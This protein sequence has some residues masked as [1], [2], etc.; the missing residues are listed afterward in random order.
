MVLAWYWGALLIVGLLLVLMFTGM[1]AGFA[2]G[3][4]AII[5]TVVFLGPNNLIVLANNAFTRGTENEFIV[6][7]LFIFMAGLVITIL[8]YARIFGTEELVGG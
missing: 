7:P 4:T 6:A 8:L 5:L 3:L 1:P 2:M